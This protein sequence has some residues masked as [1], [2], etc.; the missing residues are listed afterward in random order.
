MKY[1]L[2]FMLL[3]LI[4]LG[5][6][7]LAG[8][9][10]LFTVGNGTGNSSS[11]SYPTGY[12]NYYYGARQQ[13]LIKASE[14]T[15]IGGTAGLIQSLAFNV[16]NTNFADPH[17]GYTIKIDTTSATA[18]ST[19][20]WLPVQNTVYSGSVSPVTGWN[21][22]TFSTAFNWNG[23]SNLVVEVCFNNTSYNTNAST[24][25]TTSLGFNASHVYYDDASGICGNN[26]VINYP[27]NATSTSRPNI[28]LAIQST[29]PCS[30]TPVASTATGPASVCPNANFTL[31]LSTIYNGLG[32]TFQWQ[33]SANNTTWTNIPNA[34]ASI[35]TIS[36]TAATY[37]RCVITCS[38]S[39][40]SV[41]SA[42]L[43]VNMNNFM[44][45]YC[46]PT[47]YDGGCDYG[48]DIN[49]FTLNGINGTSISELNSGCTSPSYFKY[50]ASPVI[51]LLRG[52]SHTGTISSS[53]GSSEV[54]KIWID[55]GR[56]ASFDN[57]D[58]VASI[59]SVPSSPT[60]YSMNIPFFV[61]TGLFRM[62]VRLVWITSGFDACDDQG[63]GETQD[64]LVR[65]KPCV[66]P[67]VA[68]GNDVVLCSGASITLNA[69]NVGATY[70]WSNGASSQTV[71][72]STAGTYR[73][74]VLVNGGC[75]AE[76]TI[77]ITTGNPPS[78]SVS[79]DTTVCLGQVVPLKANTEAY[80]VLWSTG[81]TSRNILV[82]VAGS[83]TVVA[84]SPENCK[85]YD[86][87]NVMLSN[88]PI[89]ILGSDVAECPGV[90][91]TLNAGNPG[92]LYEWNTGATSQ[93]VS[94]LNAGQ[95]WVKVTT[96][97]GCYSYDTINVTHKANPTAGFTY[98][99][100]GT[101]VSFT[102]TAQNTATTLWYFGDQGTSAAVNPVHTYIMYGSYRINQVVTNTCGNDTSSV[103]ISLNPTGLTEYDA[104]SQV[105][106]YP[107]PSGGTFTIENKSGI[108]VEK[109]VV[110]D[111]AGRQVYANEHPAQQTEWQV[112]L[113]D[114]ASGLYMV[115]LHTAKG[116]LVKHLN[117][118]RK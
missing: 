27:T 26:P 88:N 85:S 2:R 35:W 16:T 66:K 69:G 22:Y 111:V 96:P 50:T 59:S 104:A 113:P 56:D 60:S 58:L 10:A 49:T 73:A 117:V 5:I 38:N 17:S 68:L 44:N 12:G 89:V 81:D 101:T 9:Q 46:T 20:G 116:T 83:Y 53:Y 92:N 36:Q 76:D 78:L 4:S 37:Y 23:T 90:P 30:G 47:Y 3:W 103:V 34:N 77:V 72:I 19:A 84:S 100:D 57:S 31:G 67:V 48:D 110:L 43:Q 61:D 33:S 115:H 97:Y 64:Y 79:N 118:I 63:N 65:I 70:T 13:F 105:R 87:V 91:V 41:N 21:T 86:T 75:V 18:L 24:Q 51:E 29:V 6:V 98:D 15:G 107:N 14:L 54:A 40:Q 114:I 8:A 82:D 108:A 71:N 109:V 1:S 32:F 39:S 80:R 42:S 74:N 52:S 55:F 25:W 45:C 94:V 99:I 95:Y 106:I 93:A 112:V 28:R 62:R 11:S 102:N 7:Q